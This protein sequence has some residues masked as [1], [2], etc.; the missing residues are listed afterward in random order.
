MPLRTA[1]QGPSICQSAFEP[2]CDPASE[3]C[4]ASREAQGPPASEEG[5]RKVQKA[6]ER[7]GAE[8]EPP[9]ELQFR[10][11]PEHDPRM[12]RGPG[13]CHGSDKGARRLPDYLPQ[14]RS[15]DDERHANGG[16]VAVLRALLPRY[17]ERVSLAGAPP[18]HVGVVVIAVSTG[19]PS[20][21][22]KMLPSL[23]FDL[24][25]P[26]LIVQHMPK[27]FTGPLTLRLEGLCVLP[28][29][30]A[31]NG[32]RIGPRAIWVAPGDA[33][34]ETLRGLDGVSTR[35]RLHQGACLNSCRPSA[36]YLFRS[37]AR[38][39]GA[40]TLAVVMTGM[41]ADGLDGARAIRA[42][43]GQVIAQD[44][45]S[46]AVWGMPGRVV[47]AGLADA[48]VSLEMMAAEIIRRVRRRPLRTAS[49]ERQAVEAGSRTLEE[50][51][52]RRFEKR[53]TREVLHGVL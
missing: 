1:E 43:G 22:E 19:G 32:E 40:G 10:P 29:R 38:V 20:A 45:A 27:L 17:Q 41:G 18:C 52:E 12:M 23:P 42:A 50:A 48:T 14:P 39:Y 9:P 15:R 3:A 47:E 51:G 44:E 8:P 53:A 49:E 11:G 36:D 6:G 13:S 28:V 26:V 37:A 24:E 31:Q 34:M 5:A 46:S 33:H 35:I 4:A 25:V 30:E 2:G 16:L 7:S 21:L